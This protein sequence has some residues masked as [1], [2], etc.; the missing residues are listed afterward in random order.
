LFAWFRIVILRSDVRILKGFGGS[1]SASSYDTSHTTCESD[2]DRFNELRPGSTPILHAVACHKTIV[3]GSTPTV[4]CVAGF[5]GNVL[6]HEEEGV[7][8][9]PPGMIG[10]CIPRGDKQLSASPKSSYA[11]ATAGKGNIPR[12]VLCLQTVRVICI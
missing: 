1:K 10:N 2:I 8:I 3:G 6:G 5:L 4:Q 12:S 9:L 7:Q 11:H